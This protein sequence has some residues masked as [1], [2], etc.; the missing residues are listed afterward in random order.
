VSYSLV[1]LALALWGGLAEVNGE[2]KRERSQCQGEAAMLGTPASRTARSWDAEW[3]IEPVEMSRRCART[4]RRGR[5][6]GDGIAWG[7]TCTAVAWWVRGVTVMSGE[8]APLT[9]PRSMK[10]LG[11]YGLRICICDRCGIPFL[12]LCLRNVLKFSMPKTH[13]LSKFA[14]QSS[15]VYPRISRSPHSV[16]H[17]TRASTNTDCKSDM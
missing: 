5:S 2:R 7:R 12:F 9:C 14:S 4:L 6:W 17:A 3:L 16:M 8:A 15:S 10:M 1:S 11:T 13:V